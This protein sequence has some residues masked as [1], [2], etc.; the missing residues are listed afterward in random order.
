MVWWVWLIA[1]VIL[2]VGELL[3]E[4]FFLFWFAAGALGATIVAIFQV[5]LP[6]QL[7]VFIIISG[8]LLF[9]S[10]QLGEKLGRGKSGMDTNAHALV[11]AT[12]IIVKEVPPHKKGVVKV[13]GEEWTCMSRDL[14]LIPEE[15]LVQVISLQGVTLTVA[16]VDERKVG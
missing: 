7:A 9:F 4:G 13:N 2:L 15:T 8:T 3:T 16:P 11:G 10:R 1:V 14:D 12:G 5:S 6:I